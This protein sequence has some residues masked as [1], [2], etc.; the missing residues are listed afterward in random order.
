LATK[1]T[2]FSWNFG[3]S[4]TS[5]I[6]NPL[7]HNYIKKGTYQI[8]LSYTHDFCP[9]YNG[10]FEGDSIKVVDPLTGSDYTMFVLAGTDTTL[11]NIKTDSGYTQYAWSP[12]IYLS[13]PNIKSPLF[14]AIRTTDYILTRT[15]TSSYCEI[16]DNYHIIVS[17]DVVV[18]IPK[19]FTPNNDGLNDV[20]KIEYGAGLSQFNYIKI[21]NRWGRL[22][23]E[24]NNI[25]ASWDGKVNGRDQDT[26][27]YSY[28]ID[29][30]TYK[31][32]RISKTGSV[33]LLR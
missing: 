5:T 4:T 15:D 29:Y 28:L 23:F 17:G 25:N 30:I 26:D 33:I 12:G 24:S 7:N 31:N 27:A 18:V 2:N 19:A 1:A 21:F 8:K 22:V 16:A 11:V 10:S 3:D 32:E 14:S 9:K 13:N 6:A 20:L